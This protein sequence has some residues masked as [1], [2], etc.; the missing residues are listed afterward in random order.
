MYN[1]LVC[2]IKGV[3]KGFLLFIEVMKLEIKELEMN[4]EFLRYIYFK[5]DW[6]V[7]YEVVYSV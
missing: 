7:F 1:M 6:K 5:F 4:F 3:M 2:N